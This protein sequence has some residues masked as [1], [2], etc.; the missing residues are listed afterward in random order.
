VEEINEILVKIRA[1]KAKKARREQ[2]LSTP[3]RPA[4]SRTPSHAKL[5][6]RPDFESDLESN[7]EFDDVQSNEDDF[8]QDESDDEI[9]HPSVG[10]NRK[11]GA[12]VSKSRARNSRVD[13]AKTQKTSTVN[14]ENQATKST[15]VNIGE[16]R[17]V[18]SNR[19]EQIVDAA[20]NVN[21]RPE[22]VIIVENDDVHVP[23]PRFAG[24]KDR[25]SPNHFLTSL[26]SRIFENFVPFPAIKSDKFVKK[27]FFLRFQCIL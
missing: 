14:V 10:G 27:I 5:P 15:S 4:T 21:Q 12:V 17:E 8:V 24:L 7:E 1:A 18:S 9:Q 26:P 3:S 20:V 13:G 2:S 22:R 19:Y 25:R 23:R 6:P 11:Q 16:R